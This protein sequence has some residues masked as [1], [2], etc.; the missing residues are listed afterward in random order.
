MF[1]IKTPSITISRKHPHYFFRQL[2]Y[3]DFDLMLIH[4]DFES[5][6]FP[7]QS[8]YFHRLFFFDL[9]Q[10]KSDDSEVVPYHV[11]IGFNVSKHPKPQLKHP[12]RQ[13]AKDEDCKEN[14]INRNYSSKN[15]FIFFS[16]QPKLNFQLKAFHFC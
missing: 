13:E 1:C 12:M 6:F 10:T 15:F 11:I 5:V 9:R 16:P 8:K 7:L 2:S 14:W 4:F 3:S